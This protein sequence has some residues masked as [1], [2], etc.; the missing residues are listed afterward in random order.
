MLLVLS[1]QK[2]T[3]ASTYWYLHQIKNISKYLFKAAITLPY[4]L[5]ILK[6]DVTKC[7]NEQLFLYAV[8]P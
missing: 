4:L 2:V 3:L 8:A 6:N 5:L 1:F 7:N